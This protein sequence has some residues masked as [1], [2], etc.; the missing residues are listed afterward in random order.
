MNRCI[1]CNGTKFRDGTVDHR[2]TVGERQLAVAMPAT[3]CEACGDAY[4]NLDALGAAEREV[5]R[6]LVEGGAPSGAAF[7]FVR[8][9]L[10]IPAKTL[11]S[12]LGVAPE[13]ISQWESGEQPVDAAVWGQLAHRAR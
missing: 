5:A 7:R 4:V 12:E 8:K 10:G 13:T 1:I 6:R 11:A 2:F 3:I 9:A